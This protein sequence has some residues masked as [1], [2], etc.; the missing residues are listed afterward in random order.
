[1][2]SPNNVYVVERYNSACHNTLAL[3]QGSLVCPLDRTLEI[4]E[5]SHRNV[6]TMGKSTMGEMAVLSAGVGLKGGKVVP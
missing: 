6:N 3:V 1:M 2:L 4:V 5:I